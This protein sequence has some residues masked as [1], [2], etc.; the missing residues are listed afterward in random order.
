MEPREVAPRVVRFGVFELDST[1]GDLRKQG[2]RCE[3]FHEAAKMD[4]QFKYAEK[5]NIGYVVIIGSQEILN[6]TCVIKNLKTGTQ[7]TVALAD[8][9]NKSFI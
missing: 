6:S 3:L 7:E 5:K 8:L 4:K 1:K 9:T 2:V